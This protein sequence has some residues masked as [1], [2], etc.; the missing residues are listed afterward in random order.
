[1]MSR[2]NS[3]VGCFDNILSA[4]KF[5]SVHERH[6]IGQVIKICQ[7]IHVNPATSSSGEHSLS[8]ARRVKAWLRSRM[9]QA[10]FTH[11]AVLNTHKIRLD[12]ICLVSVAKA[13]VSLN[14]NRNRN[15]GTFTVAD[16]H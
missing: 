9:Q 6:F 2:H 11:L 12:S 4:V 10:R 5:L 15:F 13:F 1:M 14:D 3:E 7:L 16:F 8:T